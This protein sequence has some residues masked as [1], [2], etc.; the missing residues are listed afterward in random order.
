M[1]DEFH[2][3]KKD[4]SIKTNNS[5]KNILNVVVI[6]AILLFIPMTIYLFYNRTKIGKSK[7]DSSGLVS[8]YVSPNGDD[9]N[10]GT[11]SSPFKSI[12]KA[13]MTVRDLI[14]SMTSD[15]YIY[16]REG[17]YNLSKPITITPTDSGKI[18][19]RIIYTNYKNENPVL[20]GGVDIK[21]WQVDGNRWKANI[22]TGLNFRQIYVNGERAIRARSENI[23]NTQAVAADGYNI[24]NLN[25]SSWANKSN[26]EI[27]G[28]TLWKQYRCPIENAEANGHI[29]IQQPCFANSQLHKN[30]TL[31]HIDYIE[32]ALEL[33]DS[34]REWYYDANSGWIYYMPKQGES[35]GSTQI[36][37]PAIDQFIVGNGLPT[38][39]I[40]NVTFNGLTFSYSKWSE[41]SNNNGWAEV[42]ANFV[43]KGINVSQISAVNKPLASI[44]FVNAK[45]IIFSNNKVSHVGSAAINIGEGSQNNYITGNEISDISSNGIMVGDV[46]NPKSS[47]TNLITSANNITN[48]IVYKVG[49]EFNGAVGI[50]L[51][52]TANSKVSNNTLFNL[53][54]T[55]ISIGW[56]WG[57]DDPTFAKNNIIEKNLIYDYMQTLM[58]GGG[59]YSLSAQPGNIYR[60]NVILNQKNE[61][62]AIYLDNKSRF[63]TVDN[64]VVFN[65]RRTLLAKGGD[66]I[67]KNNFWQSRYANDLWNAPD[68]GFN[69]NAFTNNKVINSLA[70]AP[71]NILTAAGTQP[72]ITFPSSTNISSGVTNIT[73]KPQPSAKSYLLRIDD[74]SDPWVCNPNSTSGDICTETTSTNYSYNFKDGHTYNI[75]IHAVNSAT[76]IYGPASSITIKVGGSIPAPISTASPAPTQKPLVIQ[77]LLPSGVISAGIKNVTWSPVTGAVKYYIRINDNIDPWVCNGITAN[78]DV[79]VET[80]SPNY[81]YNFKSGHKY[82]IWVHAVFN[83][84]IVSDPTAVSVQAN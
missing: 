63:I 39:P 27:V 71:A 10:S 67:L 22:G 54:Y 4:S 77:N 58:D 59:V 25:I 72:T 35:I 20:N 38:N 42:Q 73:W 9:A 75:W 69:P 12:E 64:N 81:S 65:N 2:F 41:P 51:G 47:D 60:N 30:F 29:K 14:P 52:Y 11:I 40:K 61:Y 55:G 74:T 70:E 50:W 84:N 44:S 78:G 68:V 45:N 62:G 43:L 1:N 3:F 16:L 57:A 32:N 26:I 83:P 53:P 34:P 36:V 19:F 46:T 24:S 5:R 37:Y 13:Q 8:F 6:I 28:N 80:S 31:N 33:L 21:N 7:A 23:T 17:N 79:C 18:G 56:G 66:N 49:Q 48:N 76:N 82:N 15:I